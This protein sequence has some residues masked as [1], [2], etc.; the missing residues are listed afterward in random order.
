[1]QYSMIREYLKN[2]LGEEYY[3]TNERNFDYQKDKINAV[4]SILAGTEFDG[5]AVVPFQI[6]F[7][8]DDID[9]TQDKLND[10]VL[11]YNRKTWNA[12]TEYVR[13]EFTNA[14]CVDKNIVGL[15]INNA[16]SF[17]IG[18]TFLIFSNIVRL[19]KLTIDGVE[20]PIYTYNLNSTGKPDSANEFSNGAVDK[21][22]LKSTISFTSHT[23]TIVLYS[24]DTDFLNKCLKISMGEED[25]NT[26]FTAVYTFTNGLTFT[27]DVINTTYANMIGSNNDIPKVQLELSPASSLLKETE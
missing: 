15:S 9:E 21:C 14:Q 12:G 27:K 16:A 18:G 10:F 26:V 24:K 23:S 6:L 3:V 4:V 8:S 22:N 2:V 17:V 7:F 20:Q 1:M 5:V 25:P 11:A 19:E 13:N